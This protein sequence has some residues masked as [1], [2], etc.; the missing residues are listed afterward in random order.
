M[1]NDTVTR[2]EAVF[3]I[4]RVAFL[5]NA[6]NSN[7]LYDLRFGTEDALH[8]P[9]RGSKVYKHL[10]P[11]ISAGLKAGA[12]AVYLSGAGPTVM[13]VTSGAAGDVFAQRSTERTEIKVANAM[14][15]TAEHHGHPGEVYITRPVVH[16][17]HIV[18]ADPT[19]FHQCF[20][21][22]W[23]RLSSSIFTIQRIE[24][25]MKKACAY[26]FLTFQQTNKQRI[27]VNFSI[28]KNSM[29]LGTRPLER[30]PNNVS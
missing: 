17:A 6:L 1:L 23:R 16:G 13:A 27:L 14:R 5:V 12:H 10:Q 8:Q 19:L 7:K 30:V 28:S 21:V 24:R 11:L 2:E 22:P 26:N 25:K 15:E 9:Q 29:A 18:A 4:G 20:E 3:N